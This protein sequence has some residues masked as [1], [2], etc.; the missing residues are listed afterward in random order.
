MRHVQHR[1]G[2]LRANGEGLVFH[3]L[4]SLGGGVTLRRLA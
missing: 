4:A 2:G 3:G 1:G